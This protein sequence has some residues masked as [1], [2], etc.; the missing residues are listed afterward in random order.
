[1]RHGVDHRKLS[2]STSHRRA[3]LRNMVTSFLEREHFITTFEK[4]KE[5]QRVAEKMVTLGRVDSLSARRKAY[6]YLNSKDVTHKLFAEI[7]PRFRN[8]PGGYTRVL[9]A[10]IRHGDAAQMA[11]IEFVEGPEGKEATKSATSG[12]AASAA[13]KAA[14]KDAK[15]KTEK[16]VAKAEAKPDAGP[17]VKKAES[18]K[19]DS[20]K[21]E[22][23]EKPTKSAA[24][25]GTAAKGAA[26][27]STKDS[28]TKTKKT[29]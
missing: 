26:K 7:G 15:P 22:S 17:E 29:K 1:M 11:V 10:G 9:R 19:A 6:S 25:A 21:V 3:L 18:K 20:K 16:G 5:L 23:K 28:K 8:R 13:K 4:A 14:K 12:K 24:K 2:R 27:K